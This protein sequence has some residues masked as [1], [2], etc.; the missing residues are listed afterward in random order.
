M[1]A[2]REEVSVVLHADVGA[3]LVVLGSVAMEEAGPLADWAS[4]DWLPVVR[5]AMLLVF[6][7]TAAV[8]CSDQAATWL[9]ERVGTE[10]LEAPALARNAGAAS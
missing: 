2:A 6:P 3:R 5:S 10:Q 7:A 9:G 8:S 1:L 4:C